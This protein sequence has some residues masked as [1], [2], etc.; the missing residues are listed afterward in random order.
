M[1]YEDALSEL[2][3]RFIEAVHRLPLSCLENQTDG[4]LVNSIAASMRHTYINLFIKNK[5]QAET[6]SFEDLSVHQRQRIESLG[7]ADDFAPG[8]SIDAVF[9]GNPLTK[10]EKRVLFLLFIQGYSAA[11]MARMD[12]VSRQSVNQTKSR[13]LRKLWE[14]IKQGEG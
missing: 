12:G 1:E 2:S 5:R 11:E 4:A 6:V 9:P 7:A 14:Y 10:H 13:A 3:L 8:N